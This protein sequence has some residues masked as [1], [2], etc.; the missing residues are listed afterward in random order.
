MNAF[1]GV[2]NENSYAAVNSSIWGS[3]K[4]FQ[5]SQWVTKEFTNPIRFRTVQST[6]NP[7]LKLQNSSQQNSVV[8]LGKYS[9]S[10]RLDIPSSQMLITGK[11]SNISMQVTSV[12]H[13]SCWSQVDTKTQYRVSQLISSLVTL[14]PT[15]DFL[16]LQTQSKRIDC[17]SVL[18]VYLDKTMQVNLVI[19]LFY[20]LCAK[21]QENFR[22][23]S[24]FQRLSTAA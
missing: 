6:Q 14:S 12:R 22:I 23:E 5:A 21:K 2:I 9:D 24:R 4:N 8:W 17:S 1:C 19:Y 7:F 11:W 10:S 20:F 16:R 18:H 3:S 15:Q 13:E